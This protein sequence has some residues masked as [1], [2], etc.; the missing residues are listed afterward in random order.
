MSFCPHF[1]KS[2]VQTFFLFLKYF[3]KS[4]GKKWKEIVSDLNVCAQ[5]LCAIAIKKT[6]SLFFCISS[7][8]KPT[9][10]RTRDFWSKGVSLKLAY[11][12]TFL[13][14]CHFND[15]QCIGKNGMFQGRVL[16]VHNGSSLSSLSTDKINKINLSEKSIQPKNR[17]HLKIIFAN[18]QQKIANLSLP[19]RE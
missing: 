19:D 11:L 1:L 10:Q 5:K 4:N 18:W 2:N 12:Q 13:S 17:T 7:L 9:S 6:N 14:F 15:F 8:G 16:L 3:G